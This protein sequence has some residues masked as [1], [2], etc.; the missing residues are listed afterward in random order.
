MNISLFYSYIRDIGISQLLAAVRVNQS[1]LRSVRAMLSILV[2]AGSASCLQAH[3]TPKPTHQSTTCSHAHF[4]PA[5]LSDWSI[6]LIYLSNESMQKQCSFQAPIKG[7]FIRKST[8]R[9]TQ[10][11]S[12]LLMIQLSST[13]L[14]I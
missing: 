14:Q 13:K 1:T 12:L 4:I 9:R 11:L 5:Q 2:K 7:P 8:S 10:A 3:N 6:R